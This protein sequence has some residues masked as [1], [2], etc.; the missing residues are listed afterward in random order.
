MPDWS[1]CPHCRSEVAWLTRAEWAEHCARYAVA[2]MA[3]PPDLPLL[4]VPYPW[5]FC[6]GCLNGG[7]LVSA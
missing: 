5:W 7:A 6:H 2:T 4:P 1:R 3:P